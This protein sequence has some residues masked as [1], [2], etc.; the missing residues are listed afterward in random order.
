MVD[1]TLDCVLNADFNRDQKIENAMVIVVIA[2]MYVVLLMAL[3]EQS[4]TAGIVTVLL[5]GILPISIILYF[6]GIPRRRK[7][8]LEAEEAKHP[9]K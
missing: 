9:E 8:R 2:W 3:A 6:A 5:Y 7:R 4:V 1:V